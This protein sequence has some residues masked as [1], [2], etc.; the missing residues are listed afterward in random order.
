M[1][2][3]LLMIITI[4]LLTLISNLIYANEMEGNTIAFDRKK[5]N[6]LACHAMEG[7]D[8]A[9]NIGPPIIAM[10]T[11][12]PDRAVLKA[13]IWDATAKNSISIMPPFGKHQILSDIEIEKLMDYLYTL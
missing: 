13:Q 1:H 6:C 9:G 7:G 2:K 12:F 5:G 10:K 11:R 4:T 8:M 3:K